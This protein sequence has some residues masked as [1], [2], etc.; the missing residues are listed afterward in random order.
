MTPTPER[1]MSD[2]V[3]S[4]EEALALIGALEAKLARINEDTAPLL[5]AVKDLDT[6]IRRKRAECSE[7]EAE[8]RALV[9]HADA[10]LMLARVEANTIAGP[11]GPL[12]VISA[13]RDEIVIRPRGL[14]S[15]QYAFTCGRGAW[16][17]GC[18]LLLN[19]AEI[20]DGTAPRAPRCPAPR[21]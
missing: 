6:R 9:W 12:V 14:V 20:L 15:V 11:F 19:A 7:I 5:A 16:A 21:I 18:C 4:P 1:N 3:P 13:T 8:H 17:W 10:R 2:P